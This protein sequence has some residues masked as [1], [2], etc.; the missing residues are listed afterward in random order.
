MA[1]AMRQLETNIPGVE[2]NE[3]QA[4]VKYSNPLKK[5]S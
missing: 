4:M 1:G 2:T 5:M 3:V